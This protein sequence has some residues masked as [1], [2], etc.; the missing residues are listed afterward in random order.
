MQTNQNDYIQ[1]NRLPIDTPDER[2]KKFLIYLCLTFIVWM[3]AGVVF[4]LSS[5]YLTLPFIFTII[6]IEKLVFK[7]EKEKEELLQQ[8]AILK[9][10]ILLYKKHNRK[11]KHRDFGLLLSGKDD[12]KDIQTLS[13]HEL[14]EK[15]GLFDSSVEEEETPTLPRTMSLGSFELSNKVNNSS[16]NNQKFKN[17]ERS[18]NLRL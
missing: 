15:F 11:L 18:S 16:L 8:R 10:N 14:H 3:P 9:E 7:K 13:R 2:N 1:F 17:S 5:I 4:G 12:D 6:L